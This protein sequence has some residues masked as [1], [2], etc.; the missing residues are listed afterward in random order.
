MKR[1]GIVLS[2][3][4][5]MLVM[6]TAVS[7]GA[8][9]FSI[10]SV[11]PEDGATN[12]TKDNMC[13][14][15]TFSTEVGNDASKKANEGKFR[16][17]DEEGTEYPTRIY[18]NKTNQKYA[19]ILIDS[20][21]VPRSG[22]GSIKDNTTYICTIDEDFVD[23][24]GTPLGEDALR[25]VSF[26]T[27]NQARNSSIYMVMM[28]LMMGMMVFFTMRGTKKKDGEEGNSM[29]KELT[30]NPYKEA[31]RTGKSVEEVIREHEKEMVKA[32]RK[33][34]RKA[35]TAAN[36]MDPHRSGEAY[37]VKKPAP[38]S[39]GG[40]TFKTGRKAAWEAKQ[41]QRAAEKA[42]RKAS[43]YAKEPKKQNT[44]QP[45]KRKKKGKR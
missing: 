37:R 42:A 24:N 44:Q 7:F 1:I 4:L 6:M 26:K 31:K 2:L 13:V 39:A 30:F 25:K 28:F 32:R 3:V 10:V 40:S 21:E 36:P 41:A 9:D 27:M 17:T 38:A 35:Q 11:N 19:L 22:D 18:Y 8:E 23:N 29:M 43:N 16:I 34:E 45:K 20:T 12:T 33:A 5:A 15:V 14:K